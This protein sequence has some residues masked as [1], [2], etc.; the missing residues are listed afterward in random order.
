[1]KK[2]LVFESPI[3]SL[4]GYG[5]HSREIASYLHKMETD[6]DL[7]FINSKWGKSPCLLSFDD[8]QIT[9]TFN[10]H[11]TTDVAENIHT[12]IKLGFPSEF[13]ALG[14]HNIGIT[15]LVESTL[16]SKDFVDGC[17][18]MD[19]VIVPSEFNKTT[20]LKSYEHHKLKNTSKINVIP[21]CVQLNNEIQ[22]NTNQPISEF[23]DIVE[24]EFCY[25][26]NGKW[27]TNPVID[28]KNVDGMIRTFIYAFKDTD[29]KPGL[30]LKTNHENYSESDYSR[31]Y[32]SI[33]NII[34][35]T[36]VST[37]SIYLLH[38]NL[39]TLEMKQLY[40]HPKIKCGINLSRGESF[41]RPILESVIAKKPVLIP[42]WSGPTEYVT[43]NKFH[44]NGKLVN[45]PD[46]DGIF[47]NGG[48]WFDIDV[49]HASVKLND[50]YNKYEEYQLETINLLDQI[51]PKYNKNSI[52]NEYKQ[53]IDAYL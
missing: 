18:T 44:I 30:I 38:G 53:V 49:D 22:H 41:G 16:C 50:I 39:S 12:Y 24:E 15:A 14:K 37:P 45:H 43:N 20:L 40:K 21:E 31:V 52:F 47:I 9:E 35:D 25:L 8:P 19:E 51:K 6:L 13:K 48:S 10:K 29:K 34:K 23:M 28:R 2:I 26:Y 1:M 7:Y 33:Q 42:A 3:T 17:N 5:E 27:N 36:T 4:S 46:I 32:K 11:I